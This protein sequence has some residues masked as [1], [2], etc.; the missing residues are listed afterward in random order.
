MDLNSLAVSASGLQPGDY[1]PNFDYMLNGTGVYATTIAHHPDPQPLAN[2]GAPG[3]H[4][5]NSAPGAVVSGHHDVLMQ[6]HRPNTNGPPVGAEAGEANGDGD[7]SA[8]NIAKIV[9]YDQW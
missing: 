1:M 8:Y 9:P 4:P 7:T 6:Q 3:R 2:G 5:A